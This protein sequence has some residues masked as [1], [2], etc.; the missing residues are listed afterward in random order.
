MFERLVKQMAKSEGVTEQLKAADQMAWVGKAEQ[1][2]AVSHWIEIVE[3]I[4]RIAYLAAITLLV[5]REPI[6][7]RSVW[8]LI[9]VLLLILF[10]LCRMDPIFCR[11]AGDRLAESRVSLCPDAACG[12]SRAL[13]LVCC[14]LA[15]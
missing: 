2:A 10:V 13:F 3:Q 12:I 15:A 8:L 14:R 4:S 1:G 6:Q 9:A 7:F 11:R 5:S